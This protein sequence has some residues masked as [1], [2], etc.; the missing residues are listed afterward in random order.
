MSKPYFREIPNFQYLNRSKEKNSNADYITVK[1]FFKRAKIKDNIFENV[2][3]FDKYVVEGDDRPDN[4]AYKLY[5]D[6]TL[7]WIILLSNNIIDVYSEWPLTQSYFKDYLIDKYGSEENLYKIKCYE[8]LEVKDSEGTVLIPKGLKLN[9]STIEWE[10][11][12]LDE[13]D[14]PIPNPDYLTIVPYKTRFFDSGFDSVIT[15]TNI[16]KPITN[17]DYEIELNDKKREIYAIKPLYLNTI[18][19]DLRDGMEYKKGSK[20][21]VSRTLLKVD[22]SNN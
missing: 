20:Q 6:S 2:T 19:N 9:N 4:V 8:T 1:N 5:K 10:E 17:Y 21:Y 11:F 22:S 16:L 7:D 14:N 15:Y 3:F 12:I 13:N 18:F